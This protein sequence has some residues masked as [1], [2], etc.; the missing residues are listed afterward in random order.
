MMVCGGDDAFWVTPK[1]AQERISDLHLEKWSPGADLSGFSN[2]E[3]IYIQ[4]TELD[5]G[6]DV[7]KRKEQV[8]LHPLTKHAL[9]HVYTLFVIMLQMN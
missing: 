7:P 3:K 9:T 6:V 4:G 5:V 8:F 1:S 2:L